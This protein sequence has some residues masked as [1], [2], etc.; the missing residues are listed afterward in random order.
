MR[1]ILPYLVTKLRNI[2][3]ES[4]YFIQQLIYSKKVKFKLLCFKL[5]IEYLH[6]KIETIAKINT[7]TMDKDR[8]SYR[9]LRHAESRRNRFLHE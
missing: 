9:H 1:S 5:Q 2:A 7:K 3:Q 8:F 6:I 4:Q